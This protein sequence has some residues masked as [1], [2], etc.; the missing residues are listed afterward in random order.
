VSGNM[1]IW[2][3]DQGLDVWSSG[4]H[5]THVGGQITT[6]V[7]DQPASLGPGCGGAQRVVRAT[8][9]TPGNGATNAL[10]IDTDLGTATASKIGT[11]GWTGETL[12]PVFFQVRLV[13]SVS[14]HNECGQYYQF[15]G[16]TVRFS[17]SVINLQTPDPVTGTTY[18]WTVPPGL[19]PLGPTD[20]ASIDVLLAAHGSFKLRCD[21]V[22]STAIEAA[23]NYNVAGFAVLTAEEVTLMN[24]LCHLMQETMP[25]PAVALRGVG[26][27]FTVGGIRYVDPLWD[28]TPDELRN[29][30]AV[31][32]RP[33]SL[34]ELGQIHARA[35]QIAKIA[36]AL[37]RQ[38][39]VV[40]EQRA[41]E[42]KA[43]FSKQQ[44]APGTRGRRR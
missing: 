35:Q 20:Q 31:L 13:P 42:D 15:Q 2:K 22:I 29:R 11:Y 36:P 4:V 37:A 10:N 44:P 7:D 40:M 43:A 24:Q 9:S 23:T 19:T 32:I 27:G 17:A 26:P 28:P 12:A 5:F 38:T 21:V 41:A 39:A 18:K 3:V 8:L 25:Q 34:R 33:F 16:S 14:P 1:V 30:G 6:R